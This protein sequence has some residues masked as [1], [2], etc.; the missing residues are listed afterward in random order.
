[1]IQTLIILFSNKLKKIAELENKTIIW[2]GDFN[3]VLNPQLDYKSI[4]I[5]NNKNTKEKLLEIIRN[6][7]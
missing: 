7:K 3:L 4:K 2:S 6:Y 5:I 1:M